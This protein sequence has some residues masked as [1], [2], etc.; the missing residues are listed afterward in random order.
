MHAPVNR[1]PIITLA[2]G[3]IHR[4]ASEA[5]AVLVDA[6]APIYQ[7]GGLVRPV[8]DDVAASAGHRTKVARLTPVKAATILDHLS[9]VADFQ[10][11]SA[12]KRRMSGPILLAK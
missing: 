10:R 1:R 5:E 4:I 2:A 9:R 11:Y 7:R 6:H 8:V 12:R 3:E